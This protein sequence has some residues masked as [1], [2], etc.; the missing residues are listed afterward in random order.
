MDS[1]DFVVSMGRG[2][3][4]GHQGNRLTCTHPKVPLQLLQHPVALTEGVGMVLMVGRG[5]RELFGRLRLVPDTI[6]PPILEWNRL[7]E[8]PEAV[9]LSL[10]GDNH[11]LIAHLKKTIPMSSKDSAGHLVRTAIVCSCHFN[12]KSNIGCQLP[13]VSSGFSC[14]HQICTGL[15]KMF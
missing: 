4:S 9:L 7:V 15:W 8:P 1:Q 2:P 10:Q 11:L 5:K 3:M 12:L 13:Q 6:C 14:R